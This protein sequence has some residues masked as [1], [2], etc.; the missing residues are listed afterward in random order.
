MEPGESPGL[1]RCCMYGVCWPWS[2]PVTGETWEGWPTSDGAYFALRHASQ[3][4][5][6]V[7]A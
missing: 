7:F 5:D 4:T 3:N 1:A 2:D 6:D